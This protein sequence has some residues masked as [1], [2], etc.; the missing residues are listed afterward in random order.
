MEL[1]G[2]LNKFTC[3]TYTFRRCFRD[4]FFFLTSASLGHLEKRMPYF[5]D[6]VRY[7]I[8]RI[9]KIGSERSTANLISLHLKG[10]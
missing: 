8:P 7:T 9:N 1:L 6:Y 5:D 3:V 4:F 2:T 10:R